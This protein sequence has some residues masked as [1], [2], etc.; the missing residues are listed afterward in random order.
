MSD[1][2]AIS[3]EDLL[4]EAERRAAALRESGQL[5]P[6]ID[7]R[8]ADDYTR[9]VRRDTERAPLDPQ[10]AIDSLRAMAPVSMSQVDIAASRPGGAALKRAANRLVRDQ[11]IG[12]A[13]QTEQA[14]LA[15]TD[16]LETMAAETERLRR[17]ADS[18]VANVDMLS[19]RVTSLERRLALLESPIESPDDP[20][21]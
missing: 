10:T 18:A 17:L 6:D 13:A 3:P 9:A 5:P 12:L 16:A 8:L 15:A 14:R 4:A 20:A 11:L 1:S 2:E 19:A 7:M 21:S